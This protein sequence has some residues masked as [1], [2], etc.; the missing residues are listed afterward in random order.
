[1]GPLPLHVVTDEHV[2]PHARSRRKYFGAAGT[3]GVLPVETTKPSE[4][5]QKRLFLEVT[6]AG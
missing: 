3:R 5:R 1:M 4:G 2:E 6:A